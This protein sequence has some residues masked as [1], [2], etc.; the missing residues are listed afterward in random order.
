MN[1]KRSSGRRLGVMRHTRLSAHGS[2]IKT[3]ASTAKTNSGKNWSS[4][5]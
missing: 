1:H 2:P 4:S 3:I 5:E